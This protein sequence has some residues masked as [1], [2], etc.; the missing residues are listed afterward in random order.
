[1]KLRSNRPILVTGSNRSG[2]TWIGK[3]ISHAPHVRYIHEP[4][5]LAIAE[6]AFNRK[7]PRWFH[8]VTPSDEDFFKDYL[9]QVLH[10]PSSPI[11]EIV[12]A[13]RQKQLRSTVSKI[14]RYCMPSLRGVRPLLKDPVAVFS[15]EWLATQFDMDV[16]VIIRHPAAYVW[17]VLK[18]PSHI[19]SFRSVFVEQPELLSKLSTLSFKNISAL[20]DEA[21]LLHRASIF[22][23]AIYSIAVDYRRQHRNWIFYRYEDLASS[24]LDKFSELCK[25][26]NLE[27]TRNVEE[28]V[29]YHAIAESSA[30]QDIH[31][32]VKR[33][34][35]EQHIFDW[36]EGL[37]EDQISTIRSL[38]EPI[39]SEFYS[40]DDW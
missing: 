28:V 23:K 12:A 18:D 35:S 29:R 10:I 39:A 8:Y 24:P 25:D 33:I 27:F 2:S 19:H 3:T 38:T 40:E 20:D 11:Q 1:M 21:S 9:K 13:Y 6:R 30:D 16:V 15:A 5:N 36:K 37:N 31:A 32:H 14:S 4:F 34:R 17:S 26:L 22:W 7:L